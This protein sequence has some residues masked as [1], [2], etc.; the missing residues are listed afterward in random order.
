MPADLVKSARQRGLDRIVITDHNN[1][2]GAIIAQQMDPDLVIVGEEIKTTK[3]E[4]LAAYVKEAIPPGLPPLQTIKRLR[5]QGAFISVSHPF[6]IRSGAWLEE[7]LLEIAPLVDAIEIFNARCMKPGANQFAARLAQ[8]QNIPG[9]A[10]SDAHISF[11]IGA[12]Y[13][14]LPEFDDPGG[15]RKVIRQGTVLGKLSPLWVH[16]FSRYARFKKGV[17]V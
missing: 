2:S 8:E 6:D 11:E 16:L 10:G 15:L 4:I 7:D 1:I 17:A 12:A 3:G 13:I 14:E 5:D 9:T